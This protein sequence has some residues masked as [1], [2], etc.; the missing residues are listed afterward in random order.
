MKKRDKIILIGMP[1]CGKTTIGRI[2]AKELKYN[3]YDMDEYIEK[4]EG[5]QIKDIF[6]KSE[7]AFRKL[8]TK[9]CLE[10]TKKK[11]CVISTGGGVIKKDININIL[12]EHGIIVFINRPIEKILKD[13]D[14]SKR[15]LLKSG[16]DKL[17]SLYEERFE[18]YKN[19]SNIEVINEGFL[20][21]TIDLTK[22]KLKG[23]IKE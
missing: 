15:P 5:I 20:R 9:A 14:I 21:D 12:K 22:L 6:K 16:K 4:N 1:G 11:R 10:L 18:K 13:I 7:D 19:C 23:K 17:Y 8:E 2:L 3:F